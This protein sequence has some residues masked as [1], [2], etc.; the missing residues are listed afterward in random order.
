[1]ARVLFDFTRITSAL[2][3]IPQKPHLFLVDLARLIEAIVLYEEVLTTVP[4]QVF[5]RELTNRSPFDFTKT[6]VYETLFH[7]ILKDI[8]EKQPD[9]NSISSV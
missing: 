8:P 9:T 3:Q 2:G 5:R 6:H 1:M 7:D 4:T